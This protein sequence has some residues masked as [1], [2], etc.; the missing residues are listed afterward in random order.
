MMAHWCAA[1]VMDMYQQRWEAR[2]VL[3]HF[4]MDGGAFEQVSAALSVQST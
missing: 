3:G 2:E 1:A 4:R